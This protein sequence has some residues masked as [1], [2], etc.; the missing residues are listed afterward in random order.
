MKRGAYDYFRKPFEPDELLAV[1]E[2]AV[3]SVRLSARQRA[4]ARAELLLARSWCS[5]RRPWRSSPCWWPSAWPRGRDGADH[6]ARAAPARSGWPRPWCAAARART[7]LRTLQLRRA[8]AEELAEAELFGHRKGAFTGA[9]R[10]RLASSARRRRA[11]C[12]STR[13]ASSTCVRRRSSC[14]CCR[15]ARCGR[16]ARIASLRGRRADAGGHPSRPRAVRARRRRSAR[17]SCTG[18]RSCSC[19]LP[20]LRERNE[21]IAVLAA[22]FL[23]SSA[24]A[25]ARGPSCSRP[26]CARVS[27]HRWPGNVRE[28]ANAIESLVALSPASELDANSC[29]AR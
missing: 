8:H 1:V 6:A 24:A 18:S 26:S 29:P 22:H 2:R 17:T 5:P 9:V 27:A 13:W 4:A 7:P 3:E 20:P 11:R 25:S 16:W 12:C 23:P 15:R 21:D 14:A 10:P 19:T 28:L